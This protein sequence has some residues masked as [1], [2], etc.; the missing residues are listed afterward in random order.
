MHGLTAEDRI[1]PGE[2]DIFKYAH[3]A[4]GALAVVPE[5]PHLALFHHDD[6]TR[7]QLP[8]KFR[9]H[10]AQGA[11]FGGKHDGIAPAA[12]AQRPE[13]PGVPGGNELAGGHDDERE[14]PMQMA[15]GR[16]TASSAEGQ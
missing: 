4:A 16:A 1:R 9:P 14:R 11:G 7:V 2:V 6:L 5:G 10:G 3:V 8:L 15:G 12:H 13:A